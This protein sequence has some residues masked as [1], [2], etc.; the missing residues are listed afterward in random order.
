MKMT[1]LR[2]TA[3]LASCLSRTKDPD[4]G[5]LFPLV[6]P[7]NGRSLS[8][9]TPIRSEGQLRNGWGN[10]PEGRVSRLAWRTEEVWSF[11]RY[12]RP[13]AATVTGSVGRGQWT[14]GLIFALSVTDEFRHNEPWCRRSFIVSNR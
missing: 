9:K 4:E 12:D 14:T 2:S 13:T 10:A 3:A 1:F 8:R 6:S 11:D 7:F 5:Y